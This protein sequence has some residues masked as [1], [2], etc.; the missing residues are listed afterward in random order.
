MWPTGNRP[1][2]SP[3]GFESCLCC[4]LCCAV[5][6][7]T[8]L[9]LNVLIGNENIV[10]ISLEAMRLAK[11]TRQSVRE[12]HSSTWRLLL[13]VRAGWLEPRVSM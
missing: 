9:C 6:H 2:S 11:C 5:S 3:P 7:Q 13:W 8:F 1:C 4:P 10:C 12:W